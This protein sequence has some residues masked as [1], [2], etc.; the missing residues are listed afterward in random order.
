MDIKVTTDFDCDAEIENFNYFID[1]DP[2]LSELL[3]K[4][5]YY[6]RTILH[7]YK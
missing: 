1:Q 2:Q 7:L 5:I 6:I 3:D 4:V